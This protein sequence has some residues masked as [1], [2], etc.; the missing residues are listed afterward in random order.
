MKKR[1]GIIAF[2]SILVP[3]TV[4]A[5]THELK[6]D[7]RNWAG[8][9][10]AGKTL[11]VKAAIGSVAV[12]GS[13]GD[14]FSVEVTRGDGTIMPRIVIAETAA[15]GA[16]VCADYLAKTGQASNCGADGKVRGLLTKGYARADLRITVPRGTAVDV[17]N[18]E[19]DIS[20]EALNASVR[21]NGGTGNV[22]VFGDGK[23]VHA[24]THRGNIDLHFTSEP[25]AQK[26]HVSVMVGTIT[27]VIP[28]T[29]KVWYKMYTHFAKINSA[30]ELRGGPKA[31]PGPETPEQRLLREIT[32]DDYSG[33]FGPRDVPALHFELFTINGEESR[34]VI[35]D[36]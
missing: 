8:R 31:A 34:I 18:L 1:F 13:V 28:P 27:L 33:G 26:A 36:K 30:Y 23:V 15:G 10:G 24:E 21:A 12:V 32:N 20:V 2:V 16:I 11:K 4:L 25:I 7:E 35:R 5:A 6:P 19:G 3:A 9:L 17:N 22:R 29:R 14:E